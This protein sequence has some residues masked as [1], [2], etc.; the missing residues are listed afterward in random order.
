[1]QVQFQESCAKVMCIICSSGKMELTGAESMLE[2]K[3]ALYKLVPILLRYR[4]PPIWMWLPER[5]RCF[6]TLSSLPSHKLVYKF[7]VVRRV[8]HS[9]YIS[10][11]WK[12]SQYRTFV[13]LQVVCGDKQ[14]KPFNHLPLRY[15]YAHFSSVLTNKIANLLRSEKGRNPVW[16]KSYEIVFSS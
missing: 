10:K 4:I 8:S 11:F 1:M 13:S 5:N 2:L 12:S 6:H 7:T 16:C 3:E 9:F 15:M 14:C